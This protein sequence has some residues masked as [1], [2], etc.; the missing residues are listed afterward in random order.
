MFHGAITVTTFNKKRSIRSIIIHKYLTILTVAHK[1]AGGFL[2][3][4]D[5]LVKTQGVKALH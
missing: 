4:S 3:I 5:K 2:V 1:T